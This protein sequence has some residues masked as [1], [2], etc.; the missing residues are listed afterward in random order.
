MSNVRAEIPITLLGDRDALSEAT[1]LLVLRQVLG[2]TGE[3]MAA[4]KGASGARVV[5]A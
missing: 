3:L 5:V 1:G 2:G 4:V